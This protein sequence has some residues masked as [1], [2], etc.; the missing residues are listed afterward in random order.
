V[1]L[2]HP[3]SI[4]FSAL[5]AATLVAGACGSSKPSAAPGGKSSTTVSASSIGP[6][7]TVADY[8]P[9]IDPTRFTT[10]VTNAY[11]PLPKGSTFVFDGTRDGK[12]THDEVVVTARTRKVM[13]VDCVV[14]E[15]TV[16]SNGALIEKTED[17]YAQDAEGTVWYFGETT[18][19]YTN[20]A[21]SSTK[22]TWEAGV[23]GAQPGVVMFANPKVGA[24]YWQEYR[25]GEAEDRAKILS[26]TET[27]TVP[28]GTFTNVLT[29]EDS[30]PLNPDKTDE[31]AYAPTLGVIHSVRIKSGHQEEKSL[32]KVIAGS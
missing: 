28:M 30:D 21:V 1:R 29:T 32:T 4:A 25:P 3:R 8:H 12:P 24:D 6:T 26:I 14:I 23:D 11:F 22:G 20:G 5:I 18:A 13:G 10:K 31:K 2:D 7:T 15:D 19:E 27:V 17:W 16:T 9:K